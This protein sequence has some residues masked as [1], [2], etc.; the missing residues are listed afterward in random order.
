MRR[1]FTSSV[2]LVVILSFAARQFRPCRRCFRLSFRG[3]AFYQRHCL[4]LG[5]HG[6]GNS[7]PGVR[8]LRCR[9]RHR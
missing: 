8:C 1:N 2:A 9:L 3:S 7:E 4:R 6:R 5:I